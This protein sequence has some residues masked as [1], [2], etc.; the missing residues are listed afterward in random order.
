MKKVNVRIKDA[1]EAVFAEFVRERS[2]YSVDSSPLRQGGTN[3]LVRAVRE[4]SPAVLKY[5]ATPDRWRNEL[6][7]LRH[8]ASTGL[9]PEVYDTLPDRLIAMEFIPGSTRV[10]SNVVSPEKLR[11]VSRQL[12]QAAGKLVGTP[13][14]G[15]LH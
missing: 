5:F 12:G 1:A 8:F 11:H 9:V 10:D 13:L 3:I 7:C 6:F 14:P 2:E 15:R 4:D